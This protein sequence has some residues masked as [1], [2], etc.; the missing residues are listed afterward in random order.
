MP[1]PVRCPSCEH[2]FRV[3]DKYAGKRGKC[4]Q[5]KAVFVAQA[6]DETEEF[7]VV[8]GETERAGS[9]AK[10]VTVPKP[11]L[12][13]TVAEKSETATA[14]DST[15]RQLKSAEPL[16]QVS[17]ASPP[18]AAPPA[19]PA[20]T[21]PSV[22]VAAAPVSKATGSSGAVYAHRR[23]KKSNTAAVIAVG[24]I[25]LLI[26]LCVGG[27]VAWSLQ[28]ELLPGVQASNNTKSDP[29]DGETD[30]VAPPP[31]DLSDDDRN[32]PTAALALEN[33]DSVKKSLIEITVIDRA[34]ATHAGRGILVHQQGWVATSYALIA[35]ASGATATFADGQRSD[36][37][38]VL[39]QR[40]ADNLAILQLDVSEDNALD[41][42]VPKLASSWEPQPGERV[43]VGTRE[44]AQPTT[45]SGSLTAQSIPAGSRMRLPA[46][47]RDGRGLRLFV[48]GQRVEDNQDGTPLLL[49][50][51]K[52]AG[53][54][55]ALGPTRRGYAMPASP[56]SEMLARA[57]TGDVMPFSEIAPPGEEPIGL[58]PVE[59]QPADQPFARL[60]ATVDLL[61]ESDWSPESLEHYEA[62][63]LLALSLDA[64]QMIVDETAGESFP[65]RQARRE[66]LRQMIQ[67]T[68][69][70]IA[71]AG[72]PDEEEQARIN[73]MG[74]RA[75]NENPGV[76]QGVFLYGKC[77]MQPFHFGDRQVNGEPGFAFEIEGTNKLVVT[78]VGIAEN[79][80][81]M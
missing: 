59:E 21:E 2:A 20:P 31:P 49:A 38:G 51:G 44:Q 66:R 57:E 74:L 9:E 72:M 56:L 32:S 34:G 43:Y 53:L 68:T 58:P 62:F 5:C 19:A 73:R 64:M 63:Q 45:I 18:R 29:A 81:T 17:A 11:K 77:V 60:Q 42:A 71:A 6:A 10:T 35:E 14:T 1:I 70:A 39:V 46:A 36:F 41:A 23:K 76:E 47:A 65:N 30:R 78:G 50:S 13:S 54:C 22:A 75:I 15:V 4:P 55:V 67:S 25:G 52:V 24:G 61:A 48:H 26:L 16:A 3:P 33:W 12:L 80:R 28:D 69:E 7:P 37:A 40:P 79:G 8:A 27:V